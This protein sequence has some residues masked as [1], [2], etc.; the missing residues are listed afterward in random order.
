MGWAGANEIFDP[1]ARKMGE[2]GVEPSAKTEV[3]ASLINL[4]QMNDWDTEGESLG[5]F[6]DDE[7]VV[8]AFRRNGVIV[9]CGEKGDLDGHAVYCERERGD[10]GHGDGQHEDWRGWKWPVAQAP[11]P[12][13]TGE[14]PRRT[15]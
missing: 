11:A 7:A 15:P 3:L 12:V 13:A 2:L 5:E 1:V 6:E 10:R 14:D 8:E 9:H 4:L